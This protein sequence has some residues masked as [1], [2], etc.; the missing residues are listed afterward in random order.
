MRE[1]NN[2]FAVILFTWVNEVPSEI[3]TQWGHQPQGNIRNKSTENCLIWEIYCLSD[4]FVW[5]AL[6]LPFAVAAF[7]TNL[8]FK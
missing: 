8:Q 6:C 7:N 1:S 4:T 5:R 2:V 3:Q